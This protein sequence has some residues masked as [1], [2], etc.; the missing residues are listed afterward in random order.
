MEQYF[1][2]SMKVF[3]ACVVAYVAMHI[4]NCLRQLSFRKIL[5]FVLGAKGKI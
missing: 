3:T 1:D 2:E 4:L 5:Y